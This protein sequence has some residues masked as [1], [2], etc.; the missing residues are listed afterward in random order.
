MPAEAVR[1]IETSSEITRVQVLSESVR[2]FATATSDHTRLLDTVVE[3]VAYALDAFVA[4]AILSDD[5]KWLTHGAAYDTDADVLDFARRTVLAEAL[6]TDAEPALQRVLETGQALILNDFGSEALRARVEPDR[7][8]AMSSLEITSVVFVALRTQ[9]ESI[10]LLCMVRRGAAC[11]PFD[12]L[13]VS[14]AR[15]LADHAA[16]AIANARLLDDERQII[17]RLRAVADAG[18]DFA[19]ATESFDDLAHVVASRIATLVGDMCSIQLVSAD[20]QWMERTCAIHHRDPALREAARRVGETARSPMGQSFSG[21]IAVTGHS[22]L[23]PNISTAELV[24]SVAE[25]RRAFVEQLAITSIAGTPIRL[26]GRTIGV[27][28]MGRSGQGRP[29]TQ[30]DLE[31]LEDIVAHAERAIASNLRADAARQAEKTQEIGRLAG[32]AAHDINN[33][34]SVIMSYSDMLIADRDEGDPMRADLLEIQSAS[35][36]AAALMRELLVL[37]HALK[38]QKKS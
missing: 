33:L 37:G 8:E 34:L 16:L 1:T 18:R 3:R 17:A 26:D 6:A 15:M 4:L 11:V 31:L 19:S 20:A 9:V 25:E 12:G 2:A 28:V 30:A 13:D 38:A 7:F 24:A 27:V 22:L 36:R 29:Y 35:E 21:R 23:M 32:N 14:F 10:G 5:G